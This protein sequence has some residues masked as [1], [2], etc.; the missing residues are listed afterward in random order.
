MKKA[1]TL[2]LCLGVFLAG[3]SQKPVK[4]PAKEIL[5]KTPAYW[6]NVLDNKM[7]TAPEKEKQELSLKNQ[8]FE[9]SGKTLR[10]GYTGVY[11]I[12]LTDL[13]GFRYDGKRNIQLDQRA[14]GGPAPPMCLHIN[15]T[16]QDRKVDMRDYGIITP[17]R[18]QGSCGGC[19]AFATAAALETAVLLKNGGDATALELSV[20]QLL[21]CA[22][23][24]PGRCGG[25]IQGDAVGYMK[26]HYI[27]TNTELA[28]AYPAV[29]SLT[30]NNYSA[31]SNLYKASAGGWVSG[32]IFLPSPSMEQMKT[33][34]CRYGSIAA[35]INATENFKHY[36]SGVYD[37]NDN[38]TVFPNHVIQIIGWDDDIQAWLIKNSWDTDWGIGGFGWVKYGTNVIGGYA[39]WIEAQAN[40][41]NPCAVVT[42]NP[43]VV[44][45]SA[46][47]AGYAELLGRFP[48]PQTQRLQSIQSNLTVDVE[49]PV[50]G[51]ADKGRK[52][53]Q[54]SSHT[55]IILGSDG[56]N[57]EWWFLPCGK[58]DEKPLYRILNNGFTKYL[59]DN[60]GIALTENANSSN[61]QL[62]FIENSTQAGIYY[63][64]N[65][66]SGKYLQLPLNNRS[67]GAI[68]SLGVY[69]G[70]DNQKFRIASLRTN[71]FLGDKEN[72]DIF[73]V[74]SH[75]TNLAL[76]LPD[77]NYSDNVQLQVWQ[78]NNGN[79]NQAFDIRWDN[80]ARAYTIFS[81]QR[82][83]GTKNIEMYGFSKDNGGRAVI[84]EKLN[85][86]N[87]FWYILPVVRESNRFLII[88]KLSGKSL[89]VSG[90]GTANGTLIQQWDFVNGGNQKWE[91]RRWQ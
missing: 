61:N 11:N 70:G 57:Q 84:W 30:C 79:R 47:G 81:R 75:A 26:D 33:A 4:T 28:F 43:N 89:D 2:L 80:D 37:L 58:V 60:A 63:V 72:T 36:A 76:D 6:K 71:A 49:D 55:Q 62:W 9:K 40:S 17:V 1:T 20:A 68:V 66:F 21:S 87:Q 90:V 13:A 35:S 14:P 42:N 85:G 82:P 77:G 15:A 54:W 51:S 67:E 53:Q 59:T 31:P 27:A 48:F 29:N 78:Q 16:P 74:P 39:V 3:F 64:K 32:S 8:A 69:T 23:T 24:V 25:G 52:V 86:E 46:G 44:N 34:I 65:Y 12:A 83:D 22:A 91:F 38:P 7:K 41:T 56:H 88:N 45:N 19:W 10:L 50:I 5:F 73:I 18:N